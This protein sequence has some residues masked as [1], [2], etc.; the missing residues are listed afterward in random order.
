MKKYLCLVTLMILLV[1]IGYSKDLKLAY[2][3]S[4]QIMGEFQESVD[5]QRVLEQEDAEF[6][7]RMKVMENEIKSLQESLEKQ[8]AMLSDEKR[9][10]RIAEIQTKM[11]NFEKFRRDT[12]GPQGKLYQRQEELTKPILEK[13]NAV[14]KRI[15]EEDNYDFIFDI[16]PG[17]VVYA[18]PADDITQRILDELQKK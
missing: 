11:E 12:W 2:I 18:K 15:G 1:Q 13:V 6:E 4:Q 16:V 10:T 3:N 8:A 7:K 17:S 14:I 9:Q 5:V